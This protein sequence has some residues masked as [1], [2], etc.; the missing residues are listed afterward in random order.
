MHL[1]Q[2]RPVYLCVCLVRVF[3][4]LC[5]INVIT[6]A[7]NLRENNGCSNLFLVF[8]QLRDKCK[9]QLF[10]F[11]SNVSINILIKSCLLVQLPQCRK[12]LQANIPVKS[13][14]LS[15]LTGGGIPC[16]F[17]SVPFYV[18]NKNPNINLRL[19]YEKKKKKKKKKK[20]TVLRLFKIAEPMKLEDQTG[21]NI[22]CCPLILASLVNMKINLNHLS[23]WFFIQKNHKILNFPWSKTI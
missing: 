23:F 7:W 6:K 11:V 10:L 15:V 5:S 14:S 12:A 19:F 22:Q 20:K 1:G 3:W 8:F 16:S 17:K 9:W 13:Y 4:D 21:C 18:C 2:F